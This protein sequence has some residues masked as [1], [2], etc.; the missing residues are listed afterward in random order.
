MMEELTITL[1]A[2]VAALLAMLRDDGC[3]GC[4]FGN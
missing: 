4:P 1:P 3:S 2:D